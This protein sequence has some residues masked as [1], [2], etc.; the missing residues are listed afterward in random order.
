MEFSEVAFPIFLCF[1][2]FVT[3]MYQV[4]G[5]F[6]GGEVTRPV[7]GLFMFNCKGLHLVRPRELRQCFFYQCKDPPGQVLFFKTRLREA[8]FCR[9]RTVENKFIPYH[10]ASAYRLSTEYTKTSSCR[11]SRAQEGRDGRRHRYCAIFASRSFLRGC[12][13]HVLLY[14]FLLFLGGLVSVTWLAAES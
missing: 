14:L 8:S 12:G 10:D 5:A 3:S 1:V 2:G 4:D 11:T 13:V 9:R 7:C 6:A